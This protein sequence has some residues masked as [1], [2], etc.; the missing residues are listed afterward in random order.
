M[1][2]VIGKIFA[3]VLD[4]SKSRVHPEW[5]II[6]SVIIF[7]SSAALSTSFWRLETGTSQNILATVALLLMTVLFVGGLRKHLKSILLIWASLFLFGV[8]MGQFRVLQVQQEFS[9]TQTYVHVTGV[10]ERLDEKVDGPARLLV[11]PDSVSGYNKALP[12]LIRVS[13]RTAIDPSIKAGS[14]VLFSARL[15]PPNGPVVPGGYDFSRAAFFGGVGADAIALSSISTVEPAVVF[16]TGTF[17][18]NVDQVREQIEASLLKNIHGQAGGVAVALTVGFRNHLSNET[19]EVLRRAGLSHLLAI[20]GLHMGLVTASGFFIFEFLI[21]LVSGLSLRV[22][23]RKLAVFPTWSVAVLYLLLSGASTSTIRAFI[24]VSVAL[25]AVITDRRVLSLRSVA[26]AAFFIVLWRPESVL[27]VGFQMSFAATAGLVAFFEV[28]NTSKTQQS[29]KSQNKLT[30]FIWY[31]F[32]IAITSFIAQ[33]SVAPFSL[34]HFQSLSIVGLVANIL[35]LP[36]MTF[37]VMPLL[38]IGVLLIPVESFSIFGGPIEYGL[39]YILNVA[40]EVAALPHAVLYTS[41]ISD[42]VLIFAV[43][44]MLALLIFRGAILNIALL[45]FVSVL[46]IFGTHKSA[47]VLISNSGKIVSVFRNETV[48]SIGGRRGSFREKLWLQ[49]WGKK[50]TER[51]K[52]LG[53]YCDVSSCGYDILGDQSYKLTYIKALSALK[54]A[55]AK[56]NIV[57]VPDRYE[58]YCRG[59]DLLITEKALERRGPLGIYLGENGQVKVEWSQP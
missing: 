1:Y 40:F 16:N 39:N 12:N 53:R 55:C 32:A 49:Y 59:A 35:A 18:S 45:T 34:Y 2:A 37:L 29:L 4:V 6:T 56:G 36:V 9:I 28:Y 25:L 54:A 52:V 5:R 8:L 46:L 27:S 15:S 30:S 38:F 11:R 58:R 21:A 43:F 51:D 26:L 31:L 13:V 22:M 7:C 14:T 23:P 17:S 3:Q 20:S 47:N 42:I 24:M 19:K 10:V 50:P 57:I 44:G 48:F 41:P 33:L